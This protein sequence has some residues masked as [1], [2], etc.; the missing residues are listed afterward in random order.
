VPD[1]VS[2]DVNSVG[3]TG[4]VCRRQVTH[5]LRGDQFGL[6][7]GFVALSLASALAGL[8]GGRCPRCRHL[9]DGQIVGAALM[10]PDRIM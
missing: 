9:L 6:T 3:Y 1:Q 4:N 7:V 5:V 8:H 2:G 10:R